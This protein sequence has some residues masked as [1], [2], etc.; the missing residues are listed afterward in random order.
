MAAGMN[1]FL[2]AVDQKGSAS[3]SAR[4][5]ITGPG[6]EPLISPISRWYA[7]VTGNLEAIGF[8]LSPQ[9]GR[10]LNQNSSVVSRHKYYAIQFIP[11]IACFKN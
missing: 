5:I 8:N 11:T 3:I 6:S 2:F 7:D 4:S 10:V 9:I 1:I